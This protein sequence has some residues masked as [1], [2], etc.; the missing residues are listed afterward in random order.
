ML[1]LPAK[2][3]VHDLVVDMLDDIAIASI[4]LL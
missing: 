4:A 1:E 3:V 2:L